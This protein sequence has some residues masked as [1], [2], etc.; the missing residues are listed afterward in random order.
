MAPIPTTRS[1]VFMKKVAI[2]TGPAE[3]A[4]IRYLAKHMT[5]ETYLITPESLGHSVEL[6]PDS[7]QFSKDTSPIL[8]TQIGWVFNRLL[9]TQSHSHSHLHFWL[10]LLDHLP[11]PVVNRPSQHFHNT[12][13]PYQIAQIITQQT[14]LLI[15]NTCYCVNQPNPHAYPIYKSISSARSW[16]QSTNERRWVSEPVYFQKRIKG[17]NI[18]VH[19]FNQQ[20]FAMAI[21]STHLDYRHPKAQPIL[22]PITLPDR[23]VSACIH[24]S[25]FFNLM[26][27]G[28]DLI[29]SDGKWYLLEINTAPGFNYF[30]RYHPHQP[31]LH[32]LLKWQ[33]AFL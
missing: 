5:K 20:C 27:S 33:G 19:T 13:K 18:R 22:H 32:A 2:L 6:G 24:L 1:V 12:C 9:D 14:P 26:L 29:H 25:Q 11:V 10:S 30:D 28:I 4:V 31:L 23:I 17:T 7:L 3:D 16:A 8:Y 15:P 21:H